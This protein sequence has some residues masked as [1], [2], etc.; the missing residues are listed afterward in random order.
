MTEIRYAEQS[1][2]NFWMSLDRHISDDAFESKVR[3][4]QAYIIY[5]DG[6][7]A[8]IMQYG[9][10]WDSEPFCNMLYI[11]E[12]YRRMG[13]GR[14]LMEHW[15][16]EMAEKGAEMVMTSTQADENAQHFYRQLGYKDSGCLMLD[17]QPME[18]IFVKN[19]KKTGA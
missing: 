7:S 2:R 8:G 11:S 12:K 5:V 10:F 9:M 19:I 15:E 17:S 18:I 1:D 6:V 3:D 4:G 14:L 16:S 13:L